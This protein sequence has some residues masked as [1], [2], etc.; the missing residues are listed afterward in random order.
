MGCVALELGYF[1]IGIK[2]G[3]CLL[4]FL[5]IMGMLDLPP[6][7]VYGLE[8]FLQVSIGSIQNVCFIS[9]FANPMSNGMFD[10]WASAAVC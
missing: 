6:H 5:H 9:F 1:Y 2:S 10:L 7:Y 4:V 3:L 8:K